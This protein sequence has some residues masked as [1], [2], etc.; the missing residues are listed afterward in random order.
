M[1]AH[2]IY[3]TSVASVY[4]HYVSKV[5]KKGRTKEEG[6]E[7]L[8]WLTGYGGSNGLCIVTPTEQRFLTDFR[9]GTGV[10]YLY[11]LVRLGFLLIPVIAARE[12]GFGVARGWAL[13]R[14][15]FWRM[16]VI[17]IVNWLPL[18]VLELVLVFLGG[19]TGSVDFPTT[20]GA[21]PLNGTCTMSVPVMYLKSSVARCVLVAT[22]LDA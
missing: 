19:G 18:L 10:A 12:P 1:T 8:C 11:S 16:F 3:R 7:I 17:L 6:D 5:E 20:P 22:P 2:R 4:P 15:N 14:G 9:Y 21:P 13:G